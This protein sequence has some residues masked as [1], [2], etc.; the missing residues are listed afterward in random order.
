[1]T[2]SESL[3]DFFTCT[4]GII[5][6]MKSN[7]EVMTNQKIV[8]KILRSLPAKYDPAVIAIEE[9]KDLTALSVDELMGSLYMHEH[10]IN[11][12]TKEPL[13]Q[14]FKSKVSMREKEATSKASSSRRERGG[15]FLQRGRSQKSDRSDEEN[16]SYTQTKGKGRANFQQRGRGFQRYDKS[17]AQC[18]YCQKY[19]HFAFECRKRIADES[20]QE[21]QYAN[22]GEGKEEYVLLTCSTEEKINEDKWYV[23]SGCSNHMTGSRDLF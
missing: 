1:M 6:Q 15:R 13:E 10:R 20:K 2:D 17:F 21:A 14:T 9:S 7:G 11:K 18:Y 8:E 16:C 3:G 12:A 22:E 23:D 4:M 19:G 5:N